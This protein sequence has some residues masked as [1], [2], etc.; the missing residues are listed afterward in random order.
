MTVHDPGDQPQNHYEV[1]SRSNWRSDAGSPGVDRILPALPAAW[2]DGEVRGLRAR[3]AVTV[4]IAW[5]GG[6][7][8]RIVLTA[9]RTG[10]LTVRSSLF[11]GGEKR[12]KA[13]AGER[14]AFTG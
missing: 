2:P 11:V 4:D 14:Y 6:T 13:R 1:R 5:S 3:G 7:A 8:R 10:Q 12:F 9:G